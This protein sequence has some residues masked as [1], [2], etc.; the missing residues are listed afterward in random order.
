MLIRRNS[1]ATFFSLSLLFILSSFFIQGC[2]KPTP[3]GNG[4]VLIGGLCIHKD[5]TY[6]SECLDRLQQG[7]LTQILDYKIKDKE[8]K[9]IYFGIVSNLEISTDLYQSTKK[10]ATV[11]L[12]LFFH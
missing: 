7:T 11:V 8:E 10:L 9:I 2:R 6:K 4:Y 3:I 1:I 12:L 5:P